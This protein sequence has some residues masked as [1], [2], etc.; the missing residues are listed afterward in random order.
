M[1]VPRALLSISSVMLFFWATRRDSMLSDAPFAAHYVPFRDAQLPEK[2][3]TNLGKRWTG[4]Q[5]RFGLLITRRGAR[6]F[7]AMTSIPAN[8]GGLH[9]SK[10]SMFSTTC[11]FL[12]RHCLCKRHRRW[13]SLPTTNGNNR[14]SNSGSAE[15]LYSS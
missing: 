15:Y 9:R 4:L 12:E 1:F 10:V 5:M 3:V 11:Y 2:Q 8:F 6:V 14:T 13:F 7:A